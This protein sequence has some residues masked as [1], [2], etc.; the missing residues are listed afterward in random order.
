[1]HR[2]LSLIVV[3]WAGAYA[4]AGDAKTPSF[5]ATD[6]PWWRGPQR[7][8]IASADQ[9][10]PLRWSETENVLW[11][12]AV[13]GRG[14]GAPTVVGDRVYLCGAD[15]SQWLLCFDRKTGKELWRHEAH[16][17][18]VVP[19]GRPNA[20]A[21]YASCTPACDGQRIFA[22]FLN[23][24]AVYATALD[25]DGKRL[26]QTKVADYSLHQGFGASP[27]IYRSLV[28]VSSDNKGGGVVAGL[29]R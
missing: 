27:A 6:W 13:P 11:K 2:F 25:L 21:S 28:I 19:A 16:R 12:A 1:M 4:P 7:D 8:G 18:G 3:L 26:W 10:P 22:N 20:K 23:A 9:Q 5:P 14:H 24:G 17:G 15:D 29:D